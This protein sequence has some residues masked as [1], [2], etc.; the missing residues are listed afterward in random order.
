MKHNLT[1]LHYIQRYTAP[2]YD[3]LNL[4][5][6]IGSMYVPY[7]LKKKLSGLIAPRHF[8]KELSSKEPVHCVFQDLVQYAA[9]VTP[10]EADVPAIQ[11]IIHTWQEEKKYGRV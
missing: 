2:V 8:R 6:P 5:P 3:I 9:L 7:E 4:L 1:T 10:G 11:A